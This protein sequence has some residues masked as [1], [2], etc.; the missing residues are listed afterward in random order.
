MWNESEA[1]ARARWQVRP[2]RR[3]EDFFAA[4]DRSRAFRRN[5]NGDGITLMGQG[6]YS[7]P[8]EFRPAGPQPVTQAAVAAL[9]AAARLRGYPPPS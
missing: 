4:V 7:T 3:T 5:P 9:A 2:A 6:G 1:P 8:D